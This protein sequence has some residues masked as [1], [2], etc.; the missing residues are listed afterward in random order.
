MVLRSQDTMLPM[1]PGRTAA[2]LPASLARTWPRAWSVFFAHSPRPPLSDGGGG[3]VT[4]LPTDV[5]PVRARTRV[6]IAIPIAVR[7][8]TSVTPY[9]GKKVRRGSASVVSSWRI[10]LMVSHIWLI[11][12]RRVS[13]F[14]AAASSRADLSTWR[15]RRPSAIRRLL[16]SS[17]SP[18]SSFCLSKAMWSSSWV[19]FARLLVSSP[20]MVCRALSSPRISG[21]LSGESL[22]ILRNRLTSA[23]VRAVSILCMASEVS[24]AI[25]PRSWCSTMSKAAAASPSCCLKEFNCLSG[26]A[27]L[28]P[29][30]IHK[31]LLLADR[32]SP[33]RLVGNGWEGTGGPRP[34]VHDLHIGVSLQSQPAINQL[35]L[36][37]WYNLSCCMGVTSGGRV[38]KIMLLM[39]SYSIGSYGVRWG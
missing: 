38:P 24:V 8:L 3:G 37:V 16:N 6:K 11:W 39:T 23:S 20:L 14:A 9:S 33:A 28:F 7:M 15:S 22:S 30:P 5:P 34:F 4:V 25:C 27:W 10:R 13:L 36:S 21:R 31:P 1:I 26:Q 19:S 35:K 18:A 12:D 29:H 2:A 17:M 32:N